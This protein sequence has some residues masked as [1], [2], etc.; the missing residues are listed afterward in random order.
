MVGQ[1]LSAFEALTVAIHEARRGYG[2]VAPNPLVG[3]VILDKDMCFL[4]SGHHARIGGDHA[5]IAALKVAQRMTGSQEGLEGAHFFV[6]LEP[7]A[8]QGRTPSCAKTLAELKIASLTYAIVD[9]NPLVSGKGADILKQAGVDVRSVPESSALSTA[10]KQDVILKAE[11]VAEIFLHR[12]RQQ[13][14][15]V[16]IKVASTL[17]GRMAL[18]SGE[19]KWITGEAARNHVHF[20]RAGY[21]AICIGRNTFVA[22]NPSLNVRHVEF[23]HLRNKAVVL[24]PKGRTLGVLAESNIMLNRAPEDIIIVTERNA[25]ATQTYAQVPS[26]VHVIEVS[27][28]SVGSFVIAELLSKLLSFGIS[29]L[30]IEGGAMT[31]GA[32]FVQ[33]KAERLHLFQAPTLL[34]SLHSTAWSAGF[35]VERMDQKVQLSQ[36]RREI[37]GNDSY[38][39]GR[40]R[41][42]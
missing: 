6:T 37:F 31:Y 32:F 13:E 22:D 11:E 15:F 39:T 21:D 20:L 17:D 38:L 30:L 16:A 8:H 35:G 26:G 7:C 28:N 42:S 25:V 12:M 33:K 1:R 18:T 34:G 24:D 14:P 19:S 36:V 10:E 41:F 40:I 5:E 9:P 23:P 4:A 29:S 2:C 3:C 27:C